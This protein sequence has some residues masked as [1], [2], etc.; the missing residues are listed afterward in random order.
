VSTLTTGRLA[1][2]MVGHLLVEVAELRVAV[3]V[4]AALTDL[5][6]GLQ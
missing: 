6:V 1:L 3:L 5:D 4:G 2:L